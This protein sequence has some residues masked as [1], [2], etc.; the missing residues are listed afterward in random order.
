MNG[1]E[2]WDTWKDSGSVSGRH[3]AIN[4]EYHFVP[5]NRHADFTDAHYEPADEST[6]PPRYYTPPE[7]TAR[8]PRKKR[9]QKGSGARN[10]GIACLVLASAVLGGAAGSALTTRKLNERIV[11]LESGLSSCEEALVQKSGAASSVASASVPRSATN[12][13][14]SDA[15]TLMSPAEIYDQAVRQAVGIRTEVTMTNFFGM[16]SSGAVSGS[17]FIISEDGYILTNYHVV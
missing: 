7:K 14:I 3:E 15:P 6:V 1:Q 9:T 11:S 17:G 13:L 4:G 10:A 2:D 8:E 16:T 12:N 5:E